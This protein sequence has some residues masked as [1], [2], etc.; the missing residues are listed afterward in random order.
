MSEQSID[1]ILSAL[2]TLRN[3]H[4]YVV[5]N[6]K[7]PELKE[8]A[9]KGVERVNCALSEFESVLSEVYGRP[10]VLE[11]KKNESF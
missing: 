10:Y 8:C 6:S 2:I 9:L 1:T 11:F 4:E 5:R 7:N 3:M